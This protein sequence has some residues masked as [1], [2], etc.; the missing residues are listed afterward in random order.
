MAKPYVLSKSKLN[1]LIEMYVGDFIE[2]LA[3]MY[4]D[5][6]IDSDEVDNTIR[7]Y[8]EANK[9]VYGFDDYDDLQRQFGDILND[10]HYFG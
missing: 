9:G 8:T 10:H 2:E 4:M 3:R 5:D 6:E 1:K 7:K